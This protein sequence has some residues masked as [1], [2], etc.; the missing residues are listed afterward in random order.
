MI[1]FNPTHSQPAGVQAA[2]LYRPGYSADSSQA[3]AVMKLVHWP[4]WCLG[5]FVFYLKQRPGRQWKAVASERLN[6]E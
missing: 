2:E 5:P 4:T 1:A 3:V 6:C